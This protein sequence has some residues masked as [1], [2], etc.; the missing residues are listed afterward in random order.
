MGRDRWSA[1]QAAYLGLARLKD[2]CG[3]GFALLDDRFCEFQKLSQPVGALC[4]RGRGI[5]RQCSQGTVEQ[6]R[7]ML[8][9]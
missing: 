2:I 7:C 6:T 4:C 8:G 3:V 1:K 5:R 9:M